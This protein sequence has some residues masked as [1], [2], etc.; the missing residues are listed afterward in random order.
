MASSSELR[1]LAVDDNASLLRFLISAFTA[2][3]CAVTS[4]STAEQALELIAGDVFDL[5]VSDIK[6]PGLS[7]LDLLRAVKG[8]HPATPVVLITGAPSVNSAVFGLRHGAYDYLPKPF[9]IKEVQHLVARVRADREKWNGQ[10]PLPAGLAE[11]L[12]RRQVSVE[13]LFRIGDLALQIKEPRVFVAKVLELTSESLRNDGSLMLLRD[14]HGAFVATQQGDPGVV[15]ELRALMHANFD[16]LAGQGGRE[17]LPLRR[18]GGRVEAVAAL[19]P[20]MGQ[21]MGVLCIARL[22]SNGAFLP[23]EADMVVGFAQATAVALQKLLLREDHERNLVDTITAFVNA[24][25]SKDPYLKGHSARVALYATEVA[26]AMGLDDETI[27]VVNRGAMLH[28]L[29]KLSI[30]DTILRKPERL[31]ADEFTLIKAHPVVGERILKPLRFLARE[32][33]AVRHH[34]ER[35]D[36]SG[37]PD[38]LSGEN[39]PLAARIVTVADVFDAVTS[40][41]PYRTA[42]SVE[43]ARQEIVRGRGTHFD[44]QAADAFLTIPLQRLV[45]IT[46][47]D[48]SLTSAPLTAEMAVRALVHA[49]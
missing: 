17:P 41:R 1:V 40:N 43:P 15:D 2:N 31:T 5:V 20:G 12:S 23:D 47:H 19:I 46:R 8:R 49:Q 10:A 16:R 22:T 24:I 33:C 25:E 3:G 37:Y 27:Q 39:I 48:D 26:Q 28:D 13:R 45:E 9:S 30:M 35:F 7:G 38:G 14:E 32:A 34:H 18:S 44:P 4:A 21:S 36:G 11:E 6:M 42:L 29:G